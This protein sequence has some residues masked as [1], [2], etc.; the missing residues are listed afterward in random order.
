MNGGGDAVDAQTMAGDPVARPE[1]HPQAR[2]VVKTEAR[3][4]IRRRGIPLLDTK[5]RASFLP[6]RNV[7]LS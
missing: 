5:I 7:N 4:E 6:C 2:F 3:R 1:E